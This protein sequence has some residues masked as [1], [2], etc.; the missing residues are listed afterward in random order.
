MENPN[1]IYKLETFDD[2]FFP[3][4]KRAKPI[5]YYVNEEGCHI[6]TSHSQNRKNGYPR[7]YRNGKRHRIAR[8]ILTLLIGPIPNGHVTRHKCDNPRCINPAHLEKGTPADNMRDRLERGMVYR[9][10]EHPF[11]KLKTPDIKIIRNSL[12]T[13]AELARI[14]GVSNSTISSVKKYKTW[15]HVSA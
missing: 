3:K 2:P 10:E 8:Y 13:H 9:G 12:I 15:K 7:I 14:F 4:T 5:Q 6:C 11:S 1:K